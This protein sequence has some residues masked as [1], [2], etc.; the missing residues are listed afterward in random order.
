MSMKKKN[1]WSAV[2]AMGLAATLSVGFV[3]CSDDDEPTPEIVTDNPLDKEVYYI[4]GKVTEGGKSLE[5]VEVSTSG[6]SVKTAADGTYQLAMDKVGTYVVTFAKDGYVTVTADA[7]ILSGTPKHGSVALSQTLTS[8]AASV[9]VSADKD[10]V[11]YDERTHVAELHI[12]AGAVPE[13]TD[14]TMTEYVKGVKVEGDH[15][16]LSTINCTPDG[17]EFGKDV[18]VVIKNTTSNAISFADVK[19]FV[20]EGND[21]KEIGTA[22]FDA[23]R[24]AYVCSLDGFSNHSFG[25]VYSE[26]AAGSSTEN[27]S[28]VTIDNLGKMEAAEQEVNGKQKIGW[29]IEGDLKQQLSSAFSA[30]SSSDVDKLASQ[31]NAAIT[32]T[33]GSTAGVEEIPFSLGTAKADGDQKM[34]IDM[35]A[36]KNLS[37][38]SVN[39]NYQGRVVPFSVKVATYAGVSTTITKEGGASHP[40]HSGGVIQ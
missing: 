7:V 17:L 34:T 4:A 14:I 10:A 11:V 5:G 18:E 2:L 24:N 27:L 31:L 13:D 3:G 1:F 22:D 25:T 37:S 36:K 8:L 6:K 23:D 16:S 30:L 35:K 9:T 29:E 26:S 21:W 12:P 20:E 28:T 38:F 15:A 40:G 39:F 32:S 33:K 19:H